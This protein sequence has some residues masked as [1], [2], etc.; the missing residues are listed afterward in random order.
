MSPQDIQFHSFEGMRTSASADIS[1]IKY[2]EFCLDETIIKFGAGDRGSGSDEDDAEQDHLH[3]ED[4]LTQVEGA[5]EGGRQAGG[6][7]RGPARAPGGEGSDYRDSVTGM[8]SAFSFCTSP[9]E[10][11]YLDVHELMRG[12]LGN[13]A[14]D[15]DVATVSGVTWMRLSALESISLCPLHI[16]NL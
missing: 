13:R 5:E 12:D 8:K 16:S 4:S 14:I 6:A 11:R 9:S 10:G 1:P 2:Q 3:R 7:A 15:H